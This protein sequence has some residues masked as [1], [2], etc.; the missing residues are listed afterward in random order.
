MSSLLQYSR[1]DEYDSRRDDHSRER[2][3]EREYRRDDRYTQ[4]EPT[5]SKDRAL[6]EDNVGHQMLKGMGWKEG[7]GLGSKG[8]GELRGEGHRPH[9][10]S[11][12]HPHP[13]T[14]PNPNAPQGS[15]PLSMTAARV[16]AI[17][18]ALAAGVPR[19]LTWLSSTAR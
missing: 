13:L 4:P 19:H 6:E 10:L 5:V 14:T 18:V 7:S 17:R 8:S 3:R 1:R 15:P 11:R 2:E 12:P 9:L 16:R